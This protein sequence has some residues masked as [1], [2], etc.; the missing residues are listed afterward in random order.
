MWDPG[1]DINTKPRV[2]LLGAGNVATSLA[3]ALRGKCEIV[4]I[5]SRTLAHAQELVERCGCGTVVDSLREVT[6][7]AD[8]YVLSVK[9][10]AIAQVAAA[11]AGGEKALWIH[12]SGSTPVDAIAGKGALYGAIHPMQ[13]FSKELPV[14]MA[15][16]HLFVEGNNEQGTEAV[17]RFA[18]LLSPHVHPV[19]WRQRERLHVAAVF[20]CNFA[21]HMFTL[22]SEVL[23]EVGLPFDPMLPIIE[24][25]V[26]K[27]RHLA[28]AESQTGPAARR[29]MA[30]L[31][32]HLESLSGD[33]REIYKLVSQSIINHASKS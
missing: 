13:S 3:P 32:R 9:D 29:D 14:D 21:N 4:Q 30:V 27:L 20:A 22:S 26:E 17:C 16:V 25:T 11:V 10:D 8:V 18:R 33:K 24:G 31:R 28:P 2:V 23:Q 15:T 6:P 1:N 5:F 12:T 7:E 19:T